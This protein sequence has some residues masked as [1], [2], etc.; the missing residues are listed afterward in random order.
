MQVDVCVRFSVLRLTCLLYGTSEWALKVACLPPSSRAYSVCFLNA[1]FLFGFWLRDFE[2]VIV[3]D[4][5]RHV[6]RHVP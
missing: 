3:R 1:P 4:F 6:G 5:D 2:T